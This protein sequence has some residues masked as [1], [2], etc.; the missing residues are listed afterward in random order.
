MNKEFHIRG[1]EKL[2]SIIRN[3]SATEKVIFGTLTLA[4][5]ICAVILAWGVNRAFL[6]S[7]PSHGGR[8]AE[9]IVGLPR[10]VNPVLAFTDVDLDLTN[11]VYSG[12]MKYEDGKLVPDLAKSYK[13]SDDGLSYSFVLRDDLRFHDG[14]PLT[15]ADVEFT[16]QKIQDSII[17]SPRRADWANI[18]THVISPTEIE[19]VLKQ[20]YAPFLANTTL[21]ILPKHIWNTI[22]PE[23]FIYSQYNIEPIGSGPYQLKNIQRDSGGIPISYAF[24]SFSR[25]KGGEPFIAEL[26]TYFY[27]NEK[28]LIDAFNKGVIESMARISA[29]EAVHIA[30]TTSVAQVLHTPLHRIFGLFF[31]QNQAPIFLQKEVRQA[32]NIATDKNEIIQ[33]VLSGY[34]IAGNGPI[35]DE[36][37]KSAKSN[38]DENLTKAQDILNKA[39]WVMDS[40]G[41][42]EKRDKKGTVQK[43]EFS[44]ATADA[45][46]LKLAGELIKA[47][48]EKLGARVTVKY[49][50]YGDLYQNIIAPRK[51]DVLLFGESIGKDL[52]LYAFWH[53]SQRN[54]PGLNVAMYVNSKVD[55]ILEDARVTTDL[56]DR[57]DLYEQFEKIIQDEVPA[58]FLYS[59]E[60]IYVVPDKVKGV[61]LEYIASPADRF[62]GIG[63]WYI[64][65]D[66]VW[67][68]FGNDDNE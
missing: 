40:D 68:V 28:A 37:A 26:Y 24:A 30:S 5:L 8:L 62:Y 17:K 53:S 57:N 3:F 2:L 60:F 48:W 47:Q 16:V 64:T 14:V 31:N 56:D 52:D 35:P 65:T 7:I 49:F 25:Y 38:A 54:S 4:A 21:G 33:K 55:K 39:G 42:M 45:P 32:L 50:D 66:S 67:K 11:L 20:P 27:P 34:G 36:K 22:S 61:D 29:N 58:V 63:K 13:V 59:P 44:I 51:Y 46:D 1:S 43:L 6:I 41:V 10:S 19:F 9:G 12:L 18:M 15:T 23:Q